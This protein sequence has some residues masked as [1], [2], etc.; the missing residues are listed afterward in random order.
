MANDPHVSENISYLGVC[1]SDLRIGSD[2]TTAHLYRT[3]RPR[4]LLYDIREKIYHIL[5]Y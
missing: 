5:V 4:G 3:M 1:E 2:V